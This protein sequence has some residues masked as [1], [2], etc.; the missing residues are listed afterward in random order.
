MFQRHQLKNYIL[1]LGA[2]KTADVDSSS[3]GGGLFSSLWGSKD[4][5]LSYNVCWC[6]SYA[7]TAKKAIP[8]NIE[9]GNVLSE[10]PGMYSAWCVFDLILY[11]CIALSGFIEKKNNSTFA[12]WVEVKAE[13]RA[14]GELVFYEK[15]TLKSDGSIELPLILNFTINK[16]ARDSNELD[17]ELADGIV[18]LK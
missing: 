1:S 15:K 5:K 18:K 10:P 2:S 9:E 13:V 7:N 11:A 16:K 4:G 17:L 12:S 6:C 3:S 14:P 8:E